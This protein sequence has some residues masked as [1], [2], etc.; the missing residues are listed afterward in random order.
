MAY[1]YEPKTLEKYFEEWK[2]NIN[3]NEQN[4]LASPFKHP[5][6]FQDFHNSLNIEETLETDFENK[7]KLS[8]DSQL[9]LNVES[10]DEMYSATAESDDISNIQQSVE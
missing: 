7:L 2:K 8:K 3:F 4:I 6:M 5:E 9:H 1:T 10:N